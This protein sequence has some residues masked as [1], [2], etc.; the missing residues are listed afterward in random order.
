[1]TTR[2][3]GASDAFTRGSTESPRSTAFFASS[4][5]ASITLGFEVLVQEVIA[6][7]STSPWPTSTFTADRA[8]GGT[9]SGVGWLLAI[10]AS[11]HALVFFAR[12]AASSTGFWLPPPAA[13]ARASPENLCASAA[14]S[15]P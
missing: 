12:E 4:P 7:M 10:S 14:A 2:E 13:G 6:A 9:R 3:P 5:A 11:V 15:L 1:M 8:V